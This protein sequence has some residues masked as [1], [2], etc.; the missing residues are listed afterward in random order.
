MRRSKCNQCEL[1]SPTGTSTK[2]VAG[3]I[4]GERREKTVGER[5]GGGGKQESESQ[6]ESER[7][8]CRSG[9]GLGSVFSSAAN[10]LNS[11]REQKNG[12][13]KNLYIYKK[14]LKK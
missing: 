3:K 7:I 11:V 13:G 6:S 10:I 1:N 14:G 2:R 8:R 4:P 12:R 5:L 9:Q